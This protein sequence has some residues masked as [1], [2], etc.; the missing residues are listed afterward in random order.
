MSAPRRRA[1]LR[2][3]GSRRARYARL[4]WFVRAARHGRRSWRPAPTAA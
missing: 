1:P 3:A 4:A 2:R